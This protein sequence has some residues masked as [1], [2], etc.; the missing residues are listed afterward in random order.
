V[1]RLS[2][3][4][5]N[6]PDPPAATTPRH[7][8]VRAKGVDTPYVYTID[9]RSITLRSIDGASTFALG[10][11]R[12]STFMFQVRVEAGGD[13]RDLP[14]WWFPQ[15]TDAFYSVPSSCVGR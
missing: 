15:S 6:A 2:H 14:Y 1:N 7:A 4:S 11:P 8:T 5:A 13:A 3:R 9:D 12:A 10:T